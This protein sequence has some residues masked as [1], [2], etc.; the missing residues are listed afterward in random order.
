MSDNGAN[1]QAPATEPRHKWAAWVGF[2][3]HLALA[4]FPYPA[5]GLLAPLYGIA[6]AYAGWLVLLF[7]ALKWWNTRPLWV[8][9]VPVIDIAW[10]FALVT[11]GDL[12]LGWTA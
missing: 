11:F 5:T 10:L 4:V 6:I 3:L 7:V 9:L 8:L 12:V 1:V 2:F